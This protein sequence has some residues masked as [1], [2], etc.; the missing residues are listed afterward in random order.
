MEVS[1]D[2]IVLK[3]RPYGERDMILTLLTPEHG[4]ITVLARS[5]GKNK[6][7]SVLYA[8]NFVFSHFVLFKGK[9]MYVV[10]SADVHEA[11]YGLRQDLSRLALA[12]YFVDVAAKSGAETDAAALCSL[13]LN[14]LYLLSSTDLDER[15]I[16]LVYETK[17]CIIE[18]VFPEVTCAR[19]GKQPAKWSFRDGFCCEEC[20]NGYPITQGMI[21]A[22]R[23]ISQNEGKKAYLFS[24]NDDSVHYLSKLLSDYVSFVTDTDFLSLEYYRSLRITL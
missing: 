11:F 16:K 3:A 13:L 23:H 9:G 4:R 22:L 1:T 10:N 20:G 21:S 6:K 12:Q 17:Y 2:G 5:V 14:S 24:M 7:Q 18:G 8:Q 15:L 19:C